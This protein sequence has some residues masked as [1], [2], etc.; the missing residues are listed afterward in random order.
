MYSFLFSSVGFNS[1]GNKASIQ[2]L[3]V[4]GGAPGYVI[5]DLTVLIDNPSAITI[6]IGDVSFD[7]IMPEYSASVGRVY[8]Y[9]TTMAPGSQV[10]KAV[11]HLA[12]GATSAEAVGKLLTYY[13]TSVVVPLTI[14]GDSK[15]TTI[16]P[17]QAA[18][19]SLKLSSPMTG[20]AG[21][22]IEKIWIVGT[23]EEM[24]APP[25]AAQ[26]SIDLY[27][28]LDTPFTLLSVQAA[29]SKFVT[30][31]FN[32]VDYTNKAVIVGTIDYTLPSP[33]VIPAKGRVRSDLWPVSINQDTGSVIS[34]LLGN[35]TFY[36]VTQ[37][38]TV[39]VGDGFHAT[40]MYYWQNEV[41]Y[42]LNLPGLTDVFAG[43]CMAD[44]SAQALSLNG[45][46]ST[47]NATSTAISSTMVTSVPL[48][49]STTVD[50]TTTSASATATEAPQPTTEAPQTT[51]EAPRTTAAP[52]TTTQDTEAPKPTPEAGAG[53]T[54]PNSSSSSA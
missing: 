45:T 11:M 36:N 8:M 46:N 1:F 24:I 2:S 12:E 33:L 50:V 31:D 3:S 29:T 26:A 27:N 42:D 21:N 40:N 10:Y 22:L 43:V 49:I 39:V 34:T 35:H 44:G 51:T 14:T 17:L 7:V 48:P 37:N 54:V 20:I 38:A 32:G 16:A 25:Y 15:S 28:P 47:A 52:Q 4:S 30:C 23:A 5:I 9:N 6:T 53:A 13:L 19:S 18:L 41:P